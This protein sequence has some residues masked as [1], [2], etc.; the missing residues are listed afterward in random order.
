MFVEYDEMQKGIACNSATAFYGY[1]INKLQ[2]TIQNIAEANAPSRSKLTALI[3][4][5]IGEQDNYVRNVVLSEKT[6]SKRY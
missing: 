5:K 1:I 3:C 2:M 6:H 4:M